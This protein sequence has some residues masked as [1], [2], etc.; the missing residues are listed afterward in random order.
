MAFARPTKR[1]KVLMKI[2]LWMPILFLL[3]LLFLVYEMRAQE[4]YVGGAGQI[5]S[6]AVWGSQDVGHH[7]SQTLVFRANTKIIFEG[8]VNPYNLRA[9]YPCPVW[10]T[11]YDDGTLTIGIDCNAVLREP[12]PVLESPLPDQIDED[13]V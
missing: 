8:N 13:E 3:V 11:L 1:E 9:D 12:V 5:Q 4:F 6:Q 2:I 10:Y 7:H